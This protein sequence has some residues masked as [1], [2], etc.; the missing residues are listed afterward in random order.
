MNNKLV[1]IITCTYN[2]EKTISDCI[3]SV[4]N[5]S[6]SN[7]EHLIIDGLSSDSTLNII[8]SINSSCKIIS[9]KDKGIYD[10][11]NKGVKYASGDIIGFLHSDDLFESKDVIELI[12]NSFNDK[13][14]GVYG[15]LNYVSQ[16]DEKKIVRKWVSCNY[17]SSMLSRGWMP[18]HPTFFLKKTVY[19]KHGNFNLKYSISADYDFMVRV[20]KDKNLNFL[21]IPSVITNMRLGG[22]SNRSLNNL[23]KKTKEDYLIIRSNGIG[24]FFTLFL[25]NFLKITQFF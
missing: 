10:A 21:F 20:L 6:Y 16:F 9:E 23:I 15:N 19:I 22:N 25:K 17:N 14:D 3:N 24:G 11:F 18:A 1:T 5:Q 13:I 8:K 12:C 2:S 4:K 7:I